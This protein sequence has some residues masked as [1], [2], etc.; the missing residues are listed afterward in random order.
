MTRQ[1][2]T[3][4]TRKALRRAIISAMNSTDDFPSYVVVFL[5]RRVRRSTLDRAALAEGA[6]VREY[7][8]GN[9]TAHIAVI[10][11]G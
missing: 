1:E 7:D 10:A 6:W 5:P 11:C 2:E 9:R 8:E 4:T 3:M